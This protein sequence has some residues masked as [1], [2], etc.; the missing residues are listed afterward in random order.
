MK[1][2]L[3]KNRVLSAL[4]CIELNMDLMKWCFR[5]DTKYWMDSKTYEVL[6]ELID[7]LSDDSKLMLKN[8][9]NVIEKCELNEKSNN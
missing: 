8:L 4:A 9:Y 6:A 7:H 2:R 1:D 3:V 5:V